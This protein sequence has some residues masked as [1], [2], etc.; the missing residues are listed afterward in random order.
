MSQWGEE[1]RAGAEGPDNGGTE[2]C[3]QP[4]AHKSK[5]AERL[6]KEPSMGAGG[7][8][9]VLGSS[10]PTSES[11]AVGLLNEVVQ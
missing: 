1:D 8:V 6:N 2:A 3:M 7:S 5:G 9:A 4:Q 10:I 11:L